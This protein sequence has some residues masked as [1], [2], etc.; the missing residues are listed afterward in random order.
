MAT[1]EVAVEPTSLPIEENVPSPK[2]KSD[3][4]P[5]GNPDAKK[6]KRSVKPLPPELEQFSQ[7]N[8]SLI[9]CALEVY[10]HGNGMVEENLAQYVDV[11]CIDEDG[12]L[13][14]K[15][16]DLHKDLNL[17]Q[18]RQFCRR[19][20]LRHTA[21]SNKHACRKAIAQAILFESGLKEH[22]LHPRNTEIRARNTLLRLINVIF[23]S[24]FIDRLL[25]IND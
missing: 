4:S 13:C 5:E 2:N 7:E 15:R 8:M 10:K 20:G 3:C 6:L 1:D 21:S 22:G 9:H 11:D 23:G 24:C 16:I 14:T 19:L 25:A 18:L 12:A 17:C